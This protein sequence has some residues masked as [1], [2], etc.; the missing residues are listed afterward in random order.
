MLITQSSKLITQTSMVITQNIM[1]I[2][3]KSTMYFDFYTKPSV[4]FECPDFGREFVRGNNWL[5]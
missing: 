5:T 4:E 1:L 3:A 2:P